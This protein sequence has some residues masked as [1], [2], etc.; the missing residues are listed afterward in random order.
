MSWNCIQVVESDNMHIRFQYL[1]VKNGGLSIHYT[2]DYGVFNEY[3]LKDLLHKV[4]FIYDPT[5]FK[6]EANIL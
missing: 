1:C 4:S 2:L 6:A 5:A 3:L